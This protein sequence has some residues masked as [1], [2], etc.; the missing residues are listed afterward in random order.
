ML[1]VNVV[2]N[3][4]CIHALLTVVASCLPL[5]VLLRPRHHRRCAQQ[6]ALQK[7]LGLPVDPDIPLLGFIGRLDY[8]KGVDLIRDSHGWLMSQ[9][10]QL[11]MLGSGRA[12]LENDLR[13]MEA[14]HNQQTRSWVGFSVKMAHRITAGVC[15][16]QQGGVLRGGVDTPF[17]RCSLTVDGVSVPVLALALMASHGVLAC[18]C[19]C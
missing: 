3:V 19:S 12:D 7:E 1:S 16:V 14:S 6:M 17:V 2:Y 5:N 15:V 11:V 18:A 10:V 9:G 4:V 8:Q 13:S